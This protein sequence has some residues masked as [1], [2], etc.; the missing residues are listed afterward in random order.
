MLTEFPQGYRYH[1]PH[2]NEDIQQWVIHHELGVHYG[3][4][5]DQV[6]QAALAVVSRY[7]TQS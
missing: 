2:W 5:L 7:F 3:D 1:E 4:T 6:R